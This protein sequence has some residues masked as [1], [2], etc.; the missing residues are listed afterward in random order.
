[1]IESNFNQ[2]VQKHLAWKQKRE[3][4]KQNG[5]EIFQLVRS[6]QATGNPKQRKL[7]AD[8]V[9]M[10]RNPLAQAGLTI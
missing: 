9:H 6:L 8:N 2:H 4:T 3:G 5:Q 1:M 10:H 7:T